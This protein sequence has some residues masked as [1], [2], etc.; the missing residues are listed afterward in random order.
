MHY[1]Y[2][3]ECRDGTLYTGYTVNVRERIREHNGKS[4]VPGAKYTRSRQPVKLRYLETHP[5][6]STAMSREYAV[7]QLTKAQ[8]QVLIRNYRIAERKQEQALE[9]KQKPVL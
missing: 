7:K 9:K 5:D 1:V 4:K 8:K 2:I 6:K 3:V